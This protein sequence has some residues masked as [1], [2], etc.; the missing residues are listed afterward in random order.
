MNINSRI[1]S[2]VLLRVVLFIMYWLFVMDSERGY[3]HILPKEQISLF[4]AKK[5]SPKNPYLSTA[6][7]SQ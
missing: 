2:V 1:F 7:S 6:T 5:L 3:S 4:H